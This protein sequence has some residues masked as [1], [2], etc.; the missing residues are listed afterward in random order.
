MVTRL[1]PKTLL[2]IVGAVLVLGGFAALVLSEDVLRA[3]LSVLFGRTEDLVYPRASLAFLLMEHLT[4]V[5]VSSALAALVGFSV[6]IAVTRPAGRD[7]LSLVQDFSSLAQTFPPV[8]VLALS[9]PALGFGFEPAVAA[10]F[11]Y[12]ILPIVN[13]T[14]SGLESVPSNVKEAATGMGM[15][16]FQVL[17]LTEIPLAAKVMIAGLR[18]SVVINVGTATVGAV[19]GAGGLGA[20]IVSGLVRDNIAYVF[21]GAATAALLALIVDWGLGKLELLVYSAQGAAEG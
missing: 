4:L 1:R 18:T 12:S 15:S 17:V 5:A 21:E 6:G 16:R 20:P 9:V 3:V 2:G 11:L 7:F 10:L 19:V 8:A 13:N 14:I